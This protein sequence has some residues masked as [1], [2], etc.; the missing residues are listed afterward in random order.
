M[1]KFLDDLRTDP[2]FARSADEIAAAFEVLDSGDT[3]DIVVAIRWVVNQPRSVRDKLL[4][5]AKMADLIIHGAKG[6]RG[7]DLFPSS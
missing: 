5:L 3:D 1:E 7:R 4:A 2:Q 6:V